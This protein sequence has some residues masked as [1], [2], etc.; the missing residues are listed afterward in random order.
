MALEMGFARIH[1]LPE[2][3][4]VIKVLNGG[5]NWMIK[6]ISHDVFLCCLLV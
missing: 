5:S 2:A 6:T 4:E 1:I 3:Q